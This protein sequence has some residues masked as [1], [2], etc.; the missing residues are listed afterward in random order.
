MGKPT[1]EVVP[2]DLEIEEEKKEAPENVCLD[3]FDLWEEI[4][5]TDGIDEEPHN[6]PGTSLFERSV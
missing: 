1:S 4:D 3:E 5:I 6:L 2:R